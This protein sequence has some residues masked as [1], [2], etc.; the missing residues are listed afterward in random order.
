[1]LTAAQTSQV[2]LFVG[3]K[4]QALH[5]EALPSAHADGS[6]RSVLVQFSYPLNYGTPVS[7]Q[8][9][10]EQRRR[11][12]DIPKPT[13]DRGRPAAVVLPTDPAYLISTDIVGP[14]LTASATARLS[15]VF[16][17]YESDF[18]RYADSHWN[19]TGAAWADDYYDR[20]QIYYAWWVRTGEVEFW[21][22]ATAMALSYRRDFLE[23]NAYGASPHWSQL[24]GLEKHYL[25]TGDEATRVAVGRVAE[26]FLKLQPEL[27]ITSSWWENRIQ[28]RLLQ[29]YFL[30]WR[31]QAVGTTPQNWAALL[32][33][34][35]TKV[36]STQ[37]ADGSYRFA[38]LCGGSLN[39]MTGLLNDQL[40]KHYTYY[41]ADPRIPGAVQGAVDFLWTTQWVPTAQAFKYNSVACAGVGDE[42]PSP[43]LNN[44]MVTGFGWLYTRTGNTVYRDRGDQIFAGGV[45]GAYLA[46][47]KQFNE[48]YTASYRYPAYRQ[49][50]R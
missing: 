35:L 2:R 1:M 41:K 27:G 32:D 7:G 18:R 15:P 12:T 47:T 21:K 3:G 42:T 44:L 6:L 37:T 22:R 49:A 11:T 46:G 8:L 16:Q 5:V 20:V 43:D 30:A 23:R 4:E 34:S 25:L 19:R 38:A 26:Q 24:E 31:L 29:A 40:I 14:T 36:L 50:S 13:A 39:Y 28:A 9:V 17:R 33:E 48:E 45:A 10:I